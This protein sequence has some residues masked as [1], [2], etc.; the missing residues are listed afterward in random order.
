MNETEIR[1]DWEKALETMEYAEIAYIIH[2]GFSMQDLFILTDLHYCGSS[3]L[4][5]KIVDL[6]EDCN[7]HTLNKYIY[8]YQYDIARQWIA[9]EY[10]LKPL[11]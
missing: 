5:Q 9:S 4:E 6:L 3:E 8:T 11:F 2:W 1:A 7:Y 10:E